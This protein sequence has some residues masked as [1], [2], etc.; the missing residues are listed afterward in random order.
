[1]I[2]SDSPQLLGWLVSQ[3]NKRKFVSRV[4]LIY[5]YVGR[6]RTHFANKLNQI[7]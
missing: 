3:T 4:T 1:M 2:T 5:S 6:H 7:Q